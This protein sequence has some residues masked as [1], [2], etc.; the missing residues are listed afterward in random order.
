ME[1]TAEYVVEQDDKKLYLI[2]LIIFLISICLFSHILQNI[3]DW[4]RKQKNRLRDLAEKDEV[5]A[6]NLA[7]LKAACKDKNLIF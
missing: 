1:G 6:N 3:A 7:K 4:L 5:W 2:D